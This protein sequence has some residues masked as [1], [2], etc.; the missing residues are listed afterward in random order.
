MGDSFRHKGGLALAALL[1]LLALFA[2]PSAASADPDTTPP[3]APAEPDGP[4]L[5]HSGDD[6][7]FTFDDTT[8]GDVDHFKCVL[9]KAPNA[10]SEEI[11]ETDD[12]CTS[13]QTFAALANATYS[14]TVQAVDAA[15]NESEPTGIVFIVGDAAPPAGTSFSFNGPAHGSAQQGPMTGF[16]GTMDTTYIGSGLYFALHNYIQRYGVAI[17]RVHPDLTLSAQASFSE[18]FSGLCFGCS[19]V[20]WSDSTPPIIAY[21]VV[22]KSGSL[23]SAE[24]QYRISATQLATVQSGKSDIV[25]M[26]TFTIDST[27]PDTA[28]DS[29]PAPGND[30]TPS[31][32]FSGTDPNPVDGKGSGIDHFECR[33]NGGAWVTCASGDPLA[34]PAP[35]GQSTFEVRAVDKAGNADGSPASTTFIVDLTPPDITITKPV[36]KDRYLLHHGPNPVFSC[37]DPLVGVPPATPAASG[38]ATCTATPINDEDLGPHFFEVTATDH[39]GNGSSKK[40]AY[41]ID[42][43]DYGGFVMES[44]PLAYYRFNE[45]LGS[46]DMLDSSGNH[47]DGIYQN[48]IALRRDGATAC[49]RRPHPPRACELA[50]PA[51]NKAAYFPARD[52]HGYVNGI[53]APTTA[54]TMEAW[55]KPRDGADMMVMSHGGGGQ[56]FIKD[57]KLAFRQVQDTI[58][59][60]GAVPAGVWSHVAA[61]WDGHNTRLYVNGVQ[62]GYSNSANKPPSGTATFYVGYGEMVPWFHGDMDEAAYYASAVSAHLIRDHW[63]VGVAKDN[64]SLI[65][66]DSPFNTEGPFTDPAAPKNGGLYAPGKVPDANFACSDPDDVP[67]NSDIASCTATVDGNPI[68]SG[69][70]LPD[71]LGSHNFTVTAIDEGGNTYVHPHTYTVKSFSDLFNADAPVAYY[72]LGDASGTMA[73]ASG[74]GHHGEYKN[75]QESGPVGISGDGDHARKFFGSSGYG[76]VNDIAAPRF[77]STLEAWVNPADARNEAIVGHGDAGEIY[78][79]DGHFVF[80]RMNTTVTAS[81][82]VVVGAWQQ[83][84]GTWDGVDIRIYVNGVEAG[85]TE[86][87]KRPSSV[88]TFYVGFGELAPWFNGSIDEVAY[89]A[90]ALNAN[91]VYQHFLA[92]PP[93]D[94][95]AAVSNASTGDPETGEPGGP[96][97]SDTPDS[98]VSDDQAKANPGDGNADPGAGKG[99]GTVEPISTEADGP[100]SLTVSRVSANRK[101]VKAFFTCGNGS[102]CVGKASGKLKLGKKKFALSGKSFAAGAGR[103]G[104]VIFKLNRKQKKAAKK[105][106]WIN[107][108]VVLKS[109]DGKILGR[110]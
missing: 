80:R 110:G 34:S 59:S 84:V 38:V 81:V 105:A 86:S 19:N 95:N 74:N 68:L 1:M 76:Y 41:T 26:R 39:A 30:T 61:T 44:H 36:N 37:V 106:K 33:V 60:S 107:V 3:P 73:D 43:P 25:D 104:S 49:E 27:A 91:R 52:G 89:Y 21:Y 78:I 31:F 48:G 4:L 79:K 92:D 90:V 63:K 97:S 2:L 99:N 18:Y 5:V 12:P 103:S 22:H 72:R 108:K 47:H 55:V 28:I 70:P 9:T 42:P 50:N 56:L 88:S 66:G 87:T 35:E 100:M 17:W 62:V 75:A 98:P 54:Y 57:G 94:G 71:S 7:T 96:G 53:T 24:G 29:S 45:S 93:P 46:D 101:K 16:S 8:G 6:A 51:E 10:P 67:G 82:P 23:P 20:D 83:V 13:P 15:D 40:V 65:A 77:Q 64:P 109:T 58:Y 85:K 102:A 14:F 32:T 69:D 11:V